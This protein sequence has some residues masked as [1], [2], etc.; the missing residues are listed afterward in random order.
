MSALGGLEPFKLP[1]SGL[2]QG[3]HSNVQDLLTMAFSKGFWA[4]QPPRVSGRRN[5]QGLLTEVN[6]KDFES[7]QL[8]RAC[9]VEQLPGASG[10]L[11]KI[12]SKVGVSYNCG[13]WRCL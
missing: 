4:R 2:G 1:W 3:N 13:M 6:S 12:V 11:V 5:F 8:P 10:L 9:V 7:K